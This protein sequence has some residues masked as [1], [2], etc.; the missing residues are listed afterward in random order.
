MDTKQE[1]YKQQKICKNKQRN[2][3]RKINGQHMN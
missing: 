1:T 3:Q 2:K